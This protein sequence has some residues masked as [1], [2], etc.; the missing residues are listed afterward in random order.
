[1]CFLQTTHKACI[2]CISGPIIK[3]FVAQLYRHEKKSFCFSVHFLDDFYVIGSNLS[4]PTAMPGP[5]I[6]P[7]YKLCGQYPGSPPL[8]KVSRVTC[9]PQPITAQY[10]YIQ[11][12]RSSDPLILELCEVWVFGSK[13]ILHSTA[14]RRSP[15]WWFQLNILPPMN[16]FW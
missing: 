4:F 11:T 15:T 9:Q 13:F 3:P 16:V 2:L 8:G 7:Q 12:N 10:I 14:K 1:M 6:G 5:L